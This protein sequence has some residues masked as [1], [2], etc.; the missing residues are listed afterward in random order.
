MLYH[1]LYGLYDGNTCLYIGRSTCS[2]PDW[3]HSL[4]N[5]SA[6]SRDITQY[7]LSNN[8]KKYVVK[9]LE[10]TKR[11]KHKKKGNNTLAFLE[12]HET[13]LPKFVNWA[14]YRKLTNPLPTFLKANY[15]DGVLLTEKSETDTTTTSTQS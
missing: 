12:C 1:Y 3:L 10:K 11:Y 9:T 13:L 4:K 14:L 8:D 7:L 5:K 2:P 15:C 6:T